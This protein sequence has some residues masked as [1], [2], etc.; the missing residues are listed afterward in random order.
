MRTHRECARSFA[1]CAAQDDNAR[2]F[3]AAA[4]PL[5]YGVR[6]VEES[7]RNGIPWCG[8]KVAAIGA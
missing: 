2:L 8:V 4:T 5:V 1:V 7:S 3:A 6:R